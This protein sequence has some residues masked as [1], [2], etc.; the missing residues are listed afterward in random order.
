MR[1]AP[2]PFALCFQACW[3][4]TPR[5]SR[6]PR[7]PVLPEV[8]GRKAEN[9]RRS[10]G[11]P[12]PRKL[13]HAGP[14]GWWQRYRDGFCQAVRGPD[15]NL[16]RRDIRW[17]CRGN[18]VTGWIDLARCAGDRRRNSFAK[19]IRCGIVATDLDIRMTTCGR[20]VLW[21]IAARR[22]F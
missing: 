7:Q 12:V 3:R 14:F 22:K 2:Y 4:V 20:P 21:Q 8:A 6:C 13:R 11:L 5:F 10:A 9:R 18:M 19:R 15:G 17:L 16:L 1:A